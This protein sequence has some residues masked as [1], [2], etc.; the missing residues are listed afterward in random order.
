M[1]KREPEA[2]DLVA[3]M[4]EAIAREVAEMK[5]DV[6]RLTDRSKGDRRGKRR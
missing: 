2:I 6:V 1:T 5:A 3:L 4:A